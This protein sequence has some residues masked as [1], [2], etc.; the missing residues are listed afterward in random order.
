MPT[1]PFLVRERR[2]ALPTKGLPAF[3]LQQDHFND[4][5]YQTL[6]SL[7]Y[8]YHEDGEIVENFIGPVKILRRGQTPQ[9]GLQLVERFDKLNTDFCS[10]GSS[11]DYY[12]RLHMLEP[13]ERLAVLQGLRDVVY[14]GRIERRFRLEPGWKISLFRDEKDDDYIQLARSLLTGEFDSLP[15]NELRFAFKLPEWR[16]TADFQLQPR[17]NSRFRGPAEP[18]LPHRMAVLIGRNGSGKSTALARLARVALGTAA[19]RQEAPL[20]QLGMIDPPSLGFPRVVTISFSP[21]DTFKL[22][23]DDARARSKVADELRQGIGRFAFIGLRDIEKEAEESERLND[24]QEAHVDRR[25]AT[26]LKSIQEIGQELVEAIHTIREKKRTKALRSAFKEM[27]H[28]SPFADLLEKAV[29]RWSDSAVRTAFFASSTGHKISSLTVAGL[30]AKLEPSS[31]VL[32]DEPETHLHPPLLAALMH[33]LRNILEE[34]RSYCIVATHSPVVLQ[35][36]LARNVYIVRRSG[37]SS[38]VVRPLRE[39][40]GESIGQI[41]AEVFGLNA[42]ST[43]YHAVLDQLVAENPQQEDLE[44]LF[45]KGRMSLQARAYAHTQ[46]AAIAEEKAARRIENSKKGDR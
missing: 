7:S 19:T 39:T 15:S 32:F 4:Y 12:E 5:G 16:A 45:F 10:V 6:Y 26:M 28:D 43:D 33:S 1:I 11:L 20:A 31:L 2:G 40:Y 3:V 46:R 38:T 22:P 23:G 37:A 27:L 41:T 42:E 35:E 44:A 18:E 29:S 17:R 9:D 24:D 8:V 25:T 34:T 13:R 36:S 30:L 14:D 21:F